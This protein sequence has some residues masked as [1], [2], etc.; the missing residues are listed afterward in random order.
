[1]KEERS[2]DIL[3]GEQTKRTLENMSFSGVP[4]SNFPQY[5][6]MAACVKAACAL[7]NQRAGLLS[8]ERALAID[9][10]CRVLH[11][12]AHLEQFPVDVYHGGGGIGINMNLNEVIAALAGEAVHPVNDVNL[13]QS[14][15]DVCHTTLRLTVRQMLADLDEECERWEHHLLLFAE[16]FQKI[17][18]IARTCWQDGLKISAGALFDGTAHALQRQ[19]RTLAH[20]QDMLVQVNLGGTVVGTGTGAPAAYRSEILQALQ[21]ITGVSVCWRESLLDAAQYP[22]DLAEVSSAVMRL[23]QILAKFSRDLRVLSSGPETGLGELHLPAVQAGSSF[24]PGKVNPVLPEMM[25]Q[26]AFLVEG[27]DHTIQQAVGQGEIHI[28]LWEE[29]M[30]F[31][32]MDNM[33]MLTRAME[34]MRIHCLDGITLDEAVCRRYA[35]SSIPQIV[36]AKET[37]GYVYLSQRIK[38]K[39]LA[40]VVEDLKQSASEQGL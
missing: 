17:P 32:L 28:N 29:M 8:Q 5:I 18:T 35:A 22:D 11:T 4:L 30:G 23:A 24:F 26:C 15:S 13:S 39:G 1:M 10:A 16:K 31:L 33:M 9:K 40:A 37:Y 6:R 19:R 12:G 38:E 3:Y 2:E 14:T 34:K 25:I 20:L 7:A 27:H 36:E 21:E